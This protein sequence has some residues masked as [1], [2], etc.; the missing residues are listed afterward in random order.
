MKKIKINIVESCNPCAAAAPLPAATSMPNAHNGQESR[1]HKTTL[2]HLM[3]DVRVMLDLIKDSDDLPEWLETKITKAGDYMS[4]A[5][6]YIAGNV[7][8]DM[9]QLEEATGEE[10]SESSNSSA[11]GG[12]IDPISAAGKKVSK[13]ELFDGIQNNVT[14]VAWL[15]E[16]DEEVSQDIVILLHGALKRAMELNGMK[17]DHI[18]Y[19]SEAGCAD[20]S[21]SPR[22]GKKVGIKVT[23]KALEE[24]AIGKEEKEWE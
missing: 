24:E 18:S 4:S 9:G 12:F 17:H 10:D 16:N 20:V 5:A 7:A 14:Q 8:R 1:M 21:P 3:A 2:A 13:E 19:L 11:E 22:L 6:R 23:F 15:L